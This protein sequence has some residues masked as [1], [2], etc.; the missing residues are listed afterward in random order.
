MKKNLFLTLLCITGIL[1]SSCNTSTNGNKE[2]N[3]TPATEPSN[4]I[5]AYL[6]AAAA[7]I[8]DHALS[9]INTL[10][11]WEDQRAQ[12][13]D[14]FMEMMGLQDMPPEGSR[15]DLNIQHTGTIQQ[16]GFR[17]EKLYYESLP[18]LYVPANLYIPDEIDEPVPAI[19]Y[20]CG[21]TNDQLAHYQP[22][23]RKFARLGFVCLIIET[24]D[25]GEVHG[26]HRGCLV[27]GW[28][29]WY[30]KGYTSGGLELWNA[31][32]GI[33]LLCEMPEVDPDRLGVTGISGGG[34]QSF[35]IAAADPRIKAAVPVGGATTL[36]G[37]I[38]QRSIDDHCDCMMPVNT[39]R[40]GFIDIGALIA[41]RPLIIAQADR[42]AYYSIESVREMYDGINKIYSLYGVPEHA[43]LEE[44]P[45]GHAYQKGIRQKIN[46]FFLEHLMG[47]E[48]TPEEAGDIDTSA[49]NQLP[50]EQ[51]RV[52]T[53]GFPPGNRTPTIQD[54]FVK[55]HEDPEITSEAELEAYRNSVT[56]F[57]KSRTFGAFP[58]E[59]AP[60]ESRHEFRSID[61]YNSVDRDVYSFISEEGWRLKVDI[62]W[63]NDPDRRKPLM[64]ALK[65]Q[66]ESQKEVKDFVAGLKEEWNIAYLEVRGVGENG[67][68]PALQRHIRRAS[69]W[70]GR[71]V[72]S[73]QVYDLMRTM[74]FCRTLDGVD[75]DR[76]G[77]AAK[78]EMAAVAMYAA[79][80]DGNCHT[81]ILKDPPATQDAP[82]RP[83]GQ[84]A[85]IEM[86]NCLRITDLGQLPALL[87][88]AKIDF[89]GEVPDTYQWPE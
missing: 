6:S 46:S 72:A 53:D 3:T 2:N 39:Y 7:E 45:R 67:W 59:K 74:E 5:R 17:I 15:T 27:R 82:S 10:K 50:I 12:R 44:Y 20:V 54:S 81:L 13:Y 34:S 64:I 38:G 33:D 52:Y 73:M 35:Y 57:L 40:R 22:F 61:D 86:L 23:A 21:H 26:E 11:E 69:A 80:L 87:A 70:T 60:F 28:Y 78:E 88:P 19:L 43:T 75:P 8:T 77:I 31:I 56:D 51:L 4:N 65:K 71:T 41:P 25:R 55:L 84:G 14:E 76:I 58:E 83:D 29:D 42:D 30:S 89:Q 68:D 24:I 32:R 18:G 36:K 9:D 1:I 48:V 16:E 85:A 47:K 79:L 63:N 66:G 37:Q 49:H 62:R